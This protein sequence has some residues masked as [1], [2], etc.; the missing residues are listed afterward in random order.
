VDRGA[1][2]QDGTISD[3]GFRADAAQVWDALLGYLGER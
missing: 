2:S 3:P 1:V